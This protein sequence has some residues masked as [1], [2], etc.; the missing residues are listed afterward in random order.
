MST[1]S[2]NPSQSFAD[3][4]ALRPPRQ[5]HTIRPHPYAPP[6]A[7]RRSSATPPSGPHTPLPPIQDLSGLSRISPID[8]HSS[9]TF[10]A[11]YTA[12]HPLFHSPSIPDNTQ[13]THGSL[14]NHFAFN[15]GTGGSNRAPQSDANRDP[16]DVHYLLPG[17]IPGHVPN[18]NAYPATSANRGAR[19]LEQLFAQF[20]LE[21]LHRQP[22]YNFTQMSGDAKLMSLFMLQLHVGSKID[23]F[24]TA[25]NDMKSQVRHIKKLCSQAWRPS[26]P[27]EAV[28][29]ISRS[30]SSHMS[31]TMPLN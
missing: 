21:L 13:V 30:L 19:E 12:G 10:G 9:V 11:P 16:L 18:S 23:K 25:L 15:A 20:N 2:L 26:E 8:P 24:S 14:T 4:S 28:T 17:R 29:P 5:T 31:K 3:G 7:G 1:E 27:Q 22:V 6:S